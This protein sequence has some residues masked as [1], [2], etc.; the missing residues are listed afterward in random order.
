MSLVTLRHVEIFLDQGSNLCPALSDGFLTT[1]LPGKS[2][3]CL[4]KKYL[5]SSTGSQVYCSS[6]VI[7]AVFVGKNFSLD[8]CTTARYPLQFNSNRDG[9][10][11][12]VGGLLLQQ[13][14]VFEGPP[15]FPGFKKNLVPGGFICEGTDPS[16]MFSVGVGSAL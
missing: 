4:L 5:R 11:Y 9:Q 14:L 13:S 16:S 12:F 3:A 15:P 10:N 7:F 2:C 8:K 1:G 6:V